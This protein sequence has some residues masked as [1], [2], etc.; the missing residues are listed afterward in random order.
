MFS[1]L[2]SLGKFM[3]FVPICRQKPYKYAIMVSCIFVCSQ[4]RTIYIG[5]LYTLSTTRENIFQT[6]EVLLILRWTLT[7]IFESFCFYRVI[8]KLENWKNLLKNIDMSSN[9]K[10][11]RSLIISICCLVY[12]IIILLEAYVYGFHFSRNFPTFFAWAI[13]YLSQ[14]SQLFYL[15]LA[16]NIVVVVAKEYSDFKQVFENQLETM[17]I[18]S[19]VTEMKR[20]TT[21][22]GK[23]YKHLHG[24]VTAFNELFS[25]SILA[26][27]C[28]MFMS[29]LCGFQFFYSL[30]VV[31]VQRDSTALVTLFISRITILSV[32]AF[33]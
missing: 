15:Y 4:V 17:V 23:K 5:Y 27:I 26:A 28:S 33:R 25:C 30:P 8:T 18:V 7:T 19:L 14:S 16:Q 13:G 24:V 6:L 22:F 9:R 31:L 3:G 12:I 10:L 32:S 1:K 11:D 2:I 21:N 20:K 29:L